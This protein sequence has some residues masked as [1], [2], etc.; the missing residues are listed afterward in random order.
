MT[1]GLL[2]RLHPRSVRALVVFAMFYVGFGV[3]LTVWQERVIYL[4][5]DQVFGDCP[6]LAGA[7]RVTYGTARMYVATGTR[8][9]VVLYH[10]NAGA[11]C[12]RAFYAERI[13]AAGYGYVL[14][15]Y[16]GYG[17]DQVAPSHDRTKAAVGDVVAYLETIAPPAVLLIGESLG[18]GVAGYH[19]E[20]VPP[21]AVLLITPF[22]SLADIARRTYW[23]YPTSWLVDNAFDNVT[24]FASYPGP[25][26]IIHGTDDTMIPP[27]S[28]QLIADARAT[29]TTEYVLI[30]DAGHNDLF[31]YE[32][33]Y[34]T[35]NSFLNKATNYDN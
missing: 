27:A 19:T 5:S 22:A 2:A 13:T 18:G 8:G 7:E 33:T 3:M 10:G 9:M 24:A 4:P 32:E 23:F 16:P 21:D 30:P 15:E 29:S 17:S 28:S 12:D 25:L 34:R 1:N 14:V 31:R 11:A 6:A 26:T 35:L 20:L